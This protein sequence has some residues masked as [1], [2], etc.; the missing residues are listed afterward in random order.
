MR[1]KLKQSTDKQ[2][3]GEETPH[4]AKFASGGRP[5]VLNPLTAEEIL[6]G[7]GYE[8]RPIHKQ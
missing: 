5:T 4:I 2:K 7:G 6:S 8:P 3:D 1:L